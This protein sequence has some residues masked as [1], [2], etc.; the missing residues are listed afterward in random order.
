[1]TILTIGSPTPSI[2]KIVPDFEYEGRPYVLYFYPKDDTPG[3]TTQACGFRDVQLTLDQL[4]IPVIGVSPDSSRSH[5]KFKVKYQLHFPLLSDES[6]QLCEAFGVWQEK[7]FMGKKSMGV[8][9]STFIID[10]QGVI[11]WVESPVRVEGHV[12]RVLKALQQLSLSS[13]EN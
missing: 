6:H 4:G 3:C 8:I 10:S 13:N 12:D 5:S 1:M 7:S 2:K 9:R 11:R